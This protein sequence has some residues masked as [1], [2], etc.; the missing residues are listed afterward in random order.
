MK[1]SILSIIALL[2]N[3]VIS[4]AKTSVMD[5]NIQE[6][7]NE[8]L[9]VIAEFDEFD[10][11]VYTFNYLDEDGNASYVM[12]DAISDDVLKKYDLKSDEYQGMKF[13]IS[14]TEH[15]QVDSDEDGD[16]QEY[17]KTTITKLTLK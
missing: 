12:F 11:E 5:V 1:L 14:Y 16:L 3:S 13:E 10:G 7:Q 15:T 6:T 9:T 8:P 17:T 4:I 2:L